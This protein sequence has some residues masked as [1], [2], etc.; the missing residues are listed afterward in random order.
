[1]NKTFFNSLKNVFIV[2]EIS[3]NHGNSIEIAVETIKAAKRAG[4][5]AVKLQTYT[6]DT[7]T[8]NSNNKDFIINSGSILRD[9][10]SFDASTIICIADRISCAVFLDLHSTAPAYA[11]ISAMC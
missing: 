6:P 4:A 11:V 8:I 7:I 1:M 2:A 9:P 3:A 10:E 5:N